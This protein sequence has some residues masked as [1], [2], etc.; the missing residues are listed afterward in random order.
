MY[1]SVGDDL[2]WEEKSVN[3]L[4]LF[5]ESELKFDNH[6][7]IICKKASQKISATLILADILSVE[8]R[9]IPLKTFLNLNL[10]IAPYSG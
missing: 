2:L 6:V 9:K 4:G 5:I 1:A 3:L 7:N 8:K 10:A